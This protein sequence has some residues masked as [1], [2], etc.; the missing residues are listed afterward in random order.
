MRQK[1]QLQ[2]P[3]QTCLGDTAVRIY[4]IKPVTSWHNITS[5]NAVES[6]LRSFI[7][8]NRQWTKI[9]ILWTIL[10]HV[11]PLKYTRARSRTL[12]IGTDLAAAIHVYSCQLDEL[13]L[14]WLPPAMYHLV[15]F[16]CIYDYAIMQYFVIFDCTLSE[17]SHAIFCDF[18][19]HVV[20]K[21]LCNTVL[22][23][24]F[25]YSA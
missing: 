15:S 11:E 2:I 6:N 3:S 23:G 9:R 25:L 14:P 21:W 7:Y 10:E 24:F 19:L 4:G 18:W 20:G 17:N 1:H 22:D 8:Q 5:R 13:R 12:P 16:V